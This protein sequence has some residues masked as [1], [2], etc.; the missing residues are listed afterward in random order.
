MKKILIA[1]A[2][3]L[4]LDWLVAQQENEKVVVV[5]GQCWYPP[6]QF[7]D[8]ELYSPTSRPDQA[9]PIMN[10]LGLSVI[11]CDDDYQSFPGPWAAKLG[12]NAAFTST[13]HQGHDAM[14]QFCVDDLSYGD[15]GLVAAM[16]CILQ[17]K[18]GKEALV[19]P[20]LE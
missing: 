12:A 18:H 10:R 13:E 11:R 7:S 2:S 3:R 8:E 6:A 14:F 9:W 15:S 5:N 20:D 4:A 16:R 19:P 17:H 1:T